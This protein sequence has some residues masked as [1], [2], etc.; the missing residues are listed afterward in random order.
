MD[1]YSSQRAYFQFGHKPFN[2]S[3]KQPLLILKTGGRTIDDESAFS[4]ILDRFA[5]TGTARLLVHG[6]GAQTAA[7]C[8]KMGIPVRMVDG[9][10]IT[11]QD[12]LKV[13]TMLYAGWLNKRIVAELQQRNCNAIGLSGADANVILAR[14]RPIKK[15]DYGFAGD[16]LSVNA[17]A[18]QR[19]LLEGLCPVLCA[20]THDAKG[21]LLNTNA[22]T[23][24]NET[25]IALAP[26]F[27]VRLWYCMDLEGVRTNPADPGSV[28]HNLDREAYG[29][30]R[31]KGIISGG[32][33]PKLD[34]AFAA[35]EQGVDEVLIG[36]IESLTGNFATRISG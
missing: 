28:L 11:D 23:I 8:R 24:A 2:M 19:F 3:D 1:V 7:L 9:R 34:N 12:T 32:M 26:Y 16:I 31:E 29:R 15:I 5:E 13:V 20:I 36:N 18:L 30:Y 21:Q 22:D 10:R 25:A 4:V 35:V 27:Q 14:K 17:S 33:I 6:G